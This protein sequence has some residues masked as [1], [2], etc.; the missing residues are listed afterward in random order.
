MMEGDATMDSNNLVKVMIDYDA[1]AGHGQCE[2][3]APDIFQVDSE[4]MV[5]LLQETVGPDLRPQLDLAIKRC[6]ECVIRFE[7]IS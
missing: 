4:G 6:P 2:A 7:M 1:C 5:H 3:V